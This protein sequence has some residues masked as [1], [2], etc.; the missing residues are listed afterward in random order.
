LLL[1]F[2][3]SDVDA[4]TQRSKPSDPA[5]IETLV[6]QLRSPSFRARL[7]AEADCREAGVEM[8]PA[9][10][11]ALKSPDPELRRRAQLLIE[12]IEDDEL[13]ESVD[14]FLAPG[15]KTELPGWSIVDELV[16]DTPAFRMAYAHV[17]QGNTQLVRALAHPQRISAEIQRELQ[18]RNMLG[19]IPQGVSPYETA[20]L[21]L[22]LIHPEADYSSD[23]SETASRQVLAGVS[24]AEFAAEPHHSPPGAT[25][26]GGD[27]V[28][29]QLLRAL[30]TRWIT[31]S[32][33]GTSHDRLVAATRLELP[34]SV[35]PALEMIQQ[36]NSPTLLG[37]AFV[38]VASYG[39]AEE[40][41]VVETLLADHFELNSSRGIG[42]KK[43]SSTQIRDLAL[44]TLIEMT[45][46]DP[47]TYGMGPFSRDEKNRLSGFPVGFEDEAR[48]DAAFEKWNAWS[49]M[50]L[51]KFRS[52]PINASEGI[53][54]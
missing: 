4:G 49:A 46:Q 20:A 17:L 16:D 28:I 45:K 33:S 52:M 14:S 26:G 24:Q 13:S 31:L 8:L 47:L 18:N 21:L 5:K 1:L 29:A 50:H 7:Q 36:K 54:L 15:S 51:R 41:A 2:Q 39:G 27:V 30:T 44:A 37:H 3:W 35:V 12:R 23:V 10:V 19:S 32:Q 48:R 9:L 25:L 43:T 6:K 42:D 11:E 40:M 34:E 22:L 38:A 53:R